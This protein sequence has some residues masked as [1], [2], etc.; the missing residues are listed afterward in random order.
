MNTKLRKLWSTLLMLLFGCTFVLAQNNTLSVKSVEGAAGKPVV[1]PVELTN[2]SEVA[3]VQ[4]DVYLPYE[5]DVLQDEATSLYL[6]AATG[7][8]AR[9]NGH[10][11]QASQ[12]P[13]SPGDTR[14]RYRVILIS[15][16]NNIVQ[17]TSGTL[18]N[19]QMTL[20]EE[21]QNGQLLSVQ[22]AN[23][24][25]SDV[26]GKAVE[27]ISMADGK[28]EIH[29]EP[30]PDI[31]PTVITADETNVNPKD[32]ITFHWTVKNQ[33]DAAAEGGW[34]ER[35]YLEN[36]RGTRIYVGSAAHSETLAAGASVSRTVT[37]ALSEYP[38]VSGYCTP[39]ITLVPNSGMNE[40]PYAA[41]NNTLAGEPNKLRVNKYLVFN[42]YV[43]GIREDS[44]DAY[45]CEVRRTG[46]VTS[47]LRIPVTIAD[48]DRLTFADA[49][50]AT[51][52]I[53]FPEGYNKAVFQVKTIDNKVVNEDNNIRIIVNPEGK[54]GDYDEVSGEVYITDDDE[55]QLQMTIDNT[56]YREDDL[57]KGTVSVPG[58]Y[59]ATIG[60]KMVVELSLTKQ[61][62]FHSPTNF[63]VVFGP[64]QL[65]SDFEIKVMDDTIPQNDIDVTLTAHSIG[66]LPVEKTF[67]LEDND[68]PPIH[69]SVSDINPNENAG[70]SAYF[71]QIQRLSDFQKPRLTIGV[72]DNSNGRLKHK[73]SYSIPEGEDWA[74]FYIGI[75]ND[76]IVQGTQQYQITFYVIPDDCACMSNKS[77]SIETMNV[78]IFDNDGPTLSIYSGGIPVVREGQ[79]GDLV[80]ERNTP[81]D[82]D[83]TVSLSCDEPRIELPATA[84]IPAGS[85]KV[86]VAYN[87]R[88]DGTQY[89][90]GIAHFKATSEGYNPS[91]AMVY[92]NDTDMPDLS[93]SN[94]TKKTE[95]STAESM[96]KLDFDVENLGYADVTTSN[97]VTFTIRSYTLTGLSSAIFTGEIPNL[98]VGEKYHGEA[99]FQ[100]PRTPDT[101]Y[102]QLEV[103]PRHTPSEVYYMNNSV[104]FSVKV[105]SAQK[106]TCQADKAA[107]NVGDVITLSGTVQKN[108]VACG[109]LV[110][111][112]FLMFNGT[113]IPLETISDETGHWTVGYTI[114]MGYAGVFGYGVDDPGSK[115]ETTVGEL[116]VYGF[117]RTNQD[118]IK[119]AK[120][121]V[122][123]PNSGHFDIRN[124]CKLDLTNIKV[125]VEDLT[126]GN[127]TVEVEP[128]VN[129]AAQG[130]ATVR[131]TITPVSA[132]LGNDWERVVLHFS[133]DQG[134][135]MDVTLFNYARMRE[136]QLLVSEPSIN[137]TVTKGIARNYPLTITNVGLGETGKI[138]VSMPEAM[139]RLI[140]LIT[141]AE[142]PSMAMGDS[143][144]IMLRLTDGDLDVNVVQN[145]WFAINTE[146]GAGK[147]V[148]FNIKVVSE[149]KG[150]LEVAVS[151]NVTYFG[152]QNGEKPY[153]KNAVA[154][155]RDYNTGK[156]LYKIS[157]E[158]S[159]DGVLRFDGVN[160]G[161]YRLYITA[162]QH[163]SFSGNVLV[164]PGTTTR[165]D[166][167][168]T[169]DAISYT[170]D[171]EETTVD[172]VYEIK[173]NVKF[174]THVPTP[175]PQIYVPDTLR[176][177]DL[178]YGKSLM[179][180]AICRNLGNI[181]L[182]N[183]RVILPQ[184]DGFTF[185]PLVE[186]Y[187]FELLPEQSYI[188]PI[189]V[190]RD[191]IKIWDA[192]EE[193]GFNKV[194]RRA[195]GTDGASCGLPHNLAGSPPCPKAGSD[196]IWGMVANALSGFPRC[197]GDASL[198]TGGSDGASGPG[199]D[200]AGAMRTPPS[201]KTKPDGVFKAQVNL[202][203]MCAILKCMPKP[204]IG[205]GL[206][207]SDAGDIGKCLMNSPEYRDE[208]LKDNEKWMKE[209]FK[210]MAKRVDG[211]QPK[212]GLHPLLKSAYRKTSLWIPYAISSD[213][214][215]SE[216]T[217]VDFESLNQSYVELGEAVEEIDAY[218]EQMDAEGRLMT[219]KPEFI[220]KMALSLA[221]IQDLYGDDPYLLQRH[222]DYH[223]SDSWK[224][225][226]MMPKKQPLFGK[227]NLS[228]YIDRFINNKLKLRGEAYDEDNCP[229]WDRV[230][231]YYAA[232]DSC[233][234]ELFKEGFVT[235]EELA[236]SINRD[237][238][239]YSDG[240]SDNI[241]AKVTLQFSQEMVFARQAFRGTMTID[242]STE[243][244]LTDVSMNVAAINQLG[245]RATS[246]EMQISMESIEGFEGEL[247][248]PWTLAPKSKGKATILFIPT[249]YAAPDTDV[250]YDFGGTL[251]FNDGNE[252]QSR[253][254]TPVTLTVK[255]SPELDMTYFMQREV[256]G[257]N[258]LTEDV[259][260]PIVPSEFT[261]LIHN[262]GK[263]T[264]TNVRMLTKQ[265]EVTDNEKALLNSYRIVGSSLNGKDHVMALDSTIATQF[266]DIPGGGSSYATWD[267]ESDLMGYFLDYDVSYSHVTSYGN[268]DLSLLD[269]V[270]IHE[271]IHSVDLIRNGKQQRAWITN[272]FED[273]HSLPDHIYFEDGTD[274]EV[275]V[276]GDV[277]NVERLETNLFRITVDLPRRG[278]FYTSM[279]NPSGGAA[280]L[281]AIYDEN[282]NNPL[283]ARNFWTTEYNITPGFDPIAENRMHICYFGDEPRKYHFLVQF[284]PMPNVYLD[285]QSIEGTPEIPA[286]DELATAPINEFTVT[287]TKDIDF[288]TF[289][290]DDLVLRY[291]GKEQ[292]A[293]GLFR[294]Q[295]MGE[296]D[297][298]HFRVFSTAL[299]NNGVY[300]LQ[301]RAQDIKDTEGFDGRNGM[302]RK[303]MLWKDR[304]VDFSLGVW[305]QQ[306][307][308][309]VSVEIGN[310]TEYNIL[311]PVGTGFEDLF[312]SEYS[313]KIRVTALA[314]PG[315]KFVYWGSVEN[316]AALDKSDFHNIAAV[317][318]RAKEGGVANVEMKKFSDNPVIDLDLVRSFNLQAVFEKEHYPVTIVYDKDYVTPS[319]ENAFVEY[320]SSL[321]LSAVG[322]EFDYEVTGYE[323]TEQDGTV[324]TYDA[325]DLTDGRLELPITG[326]TEVKIV[327]VDHTPQKFL[328]NEKLDFVNEDKE[329]VYVG[330]YRTFRRGMWNT[331]CL[332]V[333]IAQP[334]EIFGAGTQVAAFKGYDLTE[335]SLKFELVEEMEANV[336]YLITPGSLLSDNR[337]EI[338]ASIE[339]TY[340]I[341]NTSI[342][343]SVGASGTTA[344][345]DDANWEFVGTYEPTTLRGGEGNYY[346]SSNNVYYVNSTPV[347]LGRYRAYIHDKSSSGAKVYLDFGD[348]NSI[349]NVIIYDG[350]MVYDLQGRRVERHNLNDHN[351][352][353]HGVYVV[354]GKKV[355]R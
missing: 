335:G 354:D 110:V 29:N 98:K 308:G 139:S 78:E 36:R 108:G 177:Y 331:I 249:K 34:T 80:L 44:R 339:K 287:F 123:E 161:Y 290:A 43:K 292:P 149:S 280:K 293:D 260:E 169:Y 166:V 200:F 118:Y 156:M 316:D 275:Q 22:I 145:G 282:V 170:W 122:G 182:V 146:K 111:E 213:Y 75:H 221:Q 323:V 223:E 265:P 211:Q 343:A 318:R 235:W 288:T 232:I 89:N 322:N 244:P 58:R 10:T 70:D 160:E 328:L 162:E 340:T 196:D 327:F 49:E 283:S 127:Y 193:A 129:L 202:P 234:V 155:L 187:G 203:L 206:G 35:L 73:G 68:T 126:Q 296:E 313:S 185:T 243:N 304:L 90:D 154:E 20:P 71:V 158:E 164:S 269:N 273:G 82:E 305:P 184:V 349:G 56:L 157:G 228:A 242:N 353:M 55:Y 92:V 5:L 326:K 324:T 39:V 253:V 332:P 254:L 233:N 119:E 325:K 76:N 163:N 289:T 334:E 345:V 217:G 105:I 136:A 344:D 64:N 125:E 256:Y 18:V 138:T 6:P 124:L 52:F 295:K 278:W 291:E 346:I 31:V 117:A 350:K 88:R 209:H 174:E 189:V 79:K 180:T 63:K 48:H 198:D 250:A 355:V 286:D 153:V 342:K 338:G 112:P 99:Y 83:L 40:P 50:D 9:M 201:R 199:T 218:L 181:K 309:K 195:G 315:Y 321:N 65:S 246:R 69:V 134:A 297:D 194:R 77:E 212:E 248:G 150:N 197:E 25:I 45:T 298:R 130:H 97:Q 24:K 72:S 312:R 257:D 301:V 66:Y 32:D 262:K 258:P 172:D 84:V 251:Y 263:G 37:I 241:C 95:V 42:P 303:W 13:D 104:D 266:G 14:K 306:E 319:C 277:T 115:D 107:Y 62:R 259:V 151:D 41:V 188:V 310:G 220:E 47:E 2:A 132:S 175:I 341:G 140:Q 86:S 276:I 60:N 109:G 152:D 30:R 16:S 113:R 100:A 261:C 116:N 94:F 279:V 317:K 255:P 28:I 333:D 192:R 214:I 294:I 133:C 167:F 144:T 87:V 61:K 222:L 348:A 23:V 91:A 137:T 274:E 7:A 106:Y 93:L 337:G 190:T 178:D 53:V 330:L 230:A 210:F 229:D 74:E 216:K 3:A 103:N 135:K 225:S 11:V 121:Y 302:I 299:N 15:A 183:A 4:F 96:V 207:A 252:L 67:I 264:A 143:A 219:F 205:T 314:E 307:C 12:L 21:L 8:K 128:I 215:F 204:G 1:V 159:E 27:G 81:P 186:P 226:N 142:M 171:V 208:V 148:Y 239:E 238:K 141:P 165:Q 173:T 179:Y 329:N 231:E 57:I 147:N 245:V 26:R 281:L 336:P 191:E 300:S 320:G 33:G 114:P 38:G 19:L 267:I 51:T 59:E 268:P 272:D 176:I 284:E 17:G 131:Y 85:E 247:D 168:M 54:F 351:H 236:A 271:L 237:M 102:Y 227:F 270:T 311:V 120:L 101:Y 224:L 285:V 352:L 46:E 240:A 347:E